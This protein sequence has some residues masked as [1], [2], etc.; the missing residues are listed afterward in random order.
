MVGEK[1]FSKLFAANAP[2]WH[3]CTPGQLSGILFSSKEDYVYA[4]NLIALCAAL[5]WGRVKIYTF[6]VMSNHL[7]FVLSGSKEDVLEFFEEFRKRIHRFFAARKELH[8]LRGFK[9]N[10]FEII[11]LNYLRNVIA[12]VN[13]NG[14]V[15]NRHVT[16]FSYMWGPNRFF[17]F[18][19]SDFDAVVP[20]AKVSQKERQRI[21]RTHYNDF[22]DSYFFTNGYI[23]PVCYCHISECEAFFH[24]AHQY[25]HYLSRR[26]ESFSEIANQL[27]DKIVYT[28]DEVFS[29][30]IALSAKNYDIK[31][32]SAL[33]ADKRTELARSLHFS[34]NASNKQ[35][36]RV[37]GLDKAFVDAM[38]PVAK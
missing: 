4:M 35:I 24:D 33:S 6:Q 19:D 21:F 10:L 9:C 1:D 28:D 14:F 34:Y 29:A 12:Y 3:L 37:L 5:Y 13:R 20:I 31:K 18:P 32:L 8:K 30:A 2:Y 22:P 15:V 11:D 25:F 26:V 36:S 38:F 27:G 17:F 7:H 16:P 23:S